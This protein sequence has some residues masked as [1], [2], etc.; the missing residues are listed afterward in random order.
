MFGEPRRIK[1]VIIQDS[2]PILFPVY[3][4]HSSMANKE[5][6]ES[7][8]ECEISAHEGQVVVWCGGRSVSLDVKSRPEDANTIK[9]WLVTPVW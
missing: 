7:A 5:N 2:T 6:V 9:R 1:Y 3:I 4:D 8:G